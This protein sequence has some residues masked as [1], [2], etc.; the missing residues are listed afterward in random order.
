MTPVKS[1]RLRSS[2]TR[3]AFVSQLN[4]RLLGRL[5]RLGLRLGLDWLRLRRALRLLRRGLAAQ[6]GGAAAG[7]LDLLARACGERVGHDAQ[8]LRPLALAEDLHVGA[9]VLQDPGLD[10]RFR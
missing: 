9:R 7:L 5:R 3:Q 8:L 4:I 6:E 10:Q 2:G 1:T